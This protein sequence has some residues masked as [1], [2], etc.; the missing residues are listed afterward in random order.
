MLHVS[1]SF[2]SFFLYISQETKFS[3]PR[4][5]LPMPPGPS[6][7]KEKE[8]L[9]MP[10][11][12]STQ[13]ATIEHQSP[14]NGSTTTTNNG[15]T[16]GGNQQVAGTSANISIPTVTCDFA[17]DV[18]TS[19]A[20]AEMENEMYKD[21]LHVDA[22]NAQESK[23]RCFS[24]SGEEVTMNNNNS[25]RNNNN[26]SVN[27]SNGAASNETNSKMKKSPNAGRSRALSVNVD[28][29]AVS[30]FEPS[31]SD[32]GVVS[33]CAVVKPLK[34]RL[35]QPIF[36]KK[37]SK[38]NSKDHHNHHHHHHH[39][40]HDSKKLKNQ[41]VKENCETQPALPKVVKPRDP[42]KEKRRI[43]RKREKRATLIL[44][45]IMGR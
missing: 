3:N 29:D 31:S 13:I 40:Q 2:S 45:L 10:P 6:A 21:R 15:A 16:G 39:H 26:N 1:S 9:P 24:S 28:T 11:T 44:G 41:K 4:T 23:S 12:N 7:S 27:N 18:S 20:G 5:N 36:G 25:N 14:Q 43:A 38:A 22:M 35:C 30:E 37:Q 33:R 19:E 17:S 32:S 42:E 8:Q 34:F